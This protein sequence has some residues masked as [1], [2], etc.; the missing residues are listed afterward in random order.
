[1]TAAGGSL[2]QQPRH[3]LRRSQRAAHV[4]QNVRSGAVEVHLCAALSAL[5]VTCLALQSV[6]ELS[7]QFQS[8]PV[9]LALS[10]AVL[11]FAMATG[12]WLPRRV[13]LRRLASPDAALVTRADDPAFAA[14]LTGGLMLVLSAAWLLVLLAV[15]TAESL[16]AGLCRWLVSG[17][18]IVMLFTCLPGWAAMFL[19][20]MSS[21]VALAA[22][23]GWQRHLRATGG[24]LARLW[25]AVLAGTAIAA[26]LTLRLPDGLGG[27][28][29]GLASLLCAGAVCVLRPS[30]AP[31]NKPAAPATGLADLGQ[32]GALDA[33]LVATLSLELAWALFSCW[34]AAPGPL[35]LLPATALVVVGA[36]FGSLLLA[37]TID[38][39]GSALKSAGFCALL[40]AIALLWPGTGS[41]AAPAATLARL[42]LVALSACAGLAWVARS[43]TSRSRNV[44][45]AL[46]RVG[47]VAA[48]SAAAA[49]LVAAGITL[50][51]TG[52]AQTPPIAAA[53]APFGALHGLPDMAGRLDTLADVWACDLGGPRFDTLTIS[54]SACEG[55]L[56]S[57]KTPL[58]KRLMRRVRAALLPGGRVVVVVRDATTEQRLLVALGSAMPD[59]AGRGRRAPNPPIGDRLLVFGPGADEWLARRHP[60]LDSALAVERVG[61]PP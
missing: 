15:C 4:H 2:P 16:R 58:L 49:M 23:H 57:A 10:I 39:G 40:S 29:T 14:T 45:A 27:Q 28:L 11:S 36:G 43:A 24:A 56:A 47:A 60:R 42:A 55:G 26:I 6:R 34:Q 35:E 37:R 31:Q 30:G 3:A 21:T 51:I 13:I 17:P 38:P 25:L 46:R 8:P 41:S 9:A 33:A 48:M 54:P 61:S 22:L 44:Q 52:R 7:L 50:G 1:M 19:A 59:H 12:L 32:P 5:G 53:G 18:L 20:G